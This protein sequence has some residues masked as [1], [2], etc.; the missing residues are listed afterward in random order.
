MKFSENKLILIILQQ[1]CSANSPE[2]I[3]KKNY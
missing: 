3:P 2:E 1:H